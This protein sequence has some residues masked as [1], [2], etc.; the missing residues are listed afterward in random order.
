MQRWKPR[1]VFLLETKLKKYQMEKEKFKTGLSNGLIVPSLGRVGG[2]AM[3]WSRD[4]KVVVQGY[5]RNYIDAVVTDPKSG[6]KWCITRFYGYPETHRRKE[7]WDLLSDFN[8][9]VSMGEKLGGARRSQ[10]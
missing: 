6:F 4:I 9:N 5:S 10:R 1:I 7:S 8:E 2:F 3:L